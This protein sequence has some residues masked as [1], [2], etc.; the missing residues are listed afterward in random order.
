[1]D[2]LYKIYI[3]NLS[4]TSNMNIPFISVVV[5]ALNSEK[6]IERCIISLLKQQYP[7]NKYEIIIVDNGS[8]DSTLDILRKF[9]KGIIILK[10]PRKGAYKARNMGLKHAKGKIIVF[11]DSDCIADRKWIFHISKAFENKDL[12]LV[13]GAIKAFNTNNTLLKYCNEYSHMQ[14]SFL[15]SNVPSFAAANMAFNKKALK[16][17]ITFNESLERGADT[18]FCSRIIKNNNEICYEPKA[19]VRHVYGTSLVELL[20][21]QYDYGK[22]NRIIKQNLGIHHK[23]ILPKHIQIFK[24]HGLIF[25]FLRILE[26]ISWKFGYYLGSIKNV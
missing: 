9:E 4:L 3:Y 24:S 23:I 22:W 7:K 16:Q 21:K 11:T 10:E 2:N 6:T 1:M 19:L 26:D 17:P 12:K 20:K 5:P 13:G 14:K 18:E 15:V 8:K 25:L